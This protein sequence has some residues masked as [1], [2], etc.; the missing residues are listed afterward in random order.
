QADAQAALGKILRTSDPQGQILKLFDR[1]NV[2]FARDVEPWLGDKVAAAALTLGRGG[3]KVVV[4]ASRDDAEAQAALRRIAPDA[5]TR[6]D[7]G[8]SYR[9]DTKQHGFAAGV[10]GDDVV[11]GGENGLKA[12]ID[13]SK[14]D[15]LADGD[16]LKN[17]RST[18]RQQRSA[19]LYVDVAG[20]LRQTLANAGGGAQ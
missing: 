12:A 20:V 3:D 15:S 5:A 17:A 7:R 4:A 19:F 14:G 13:A 16:A 2:R 11:L 1:G 10:V 8:V 6:T 18:V 9:V